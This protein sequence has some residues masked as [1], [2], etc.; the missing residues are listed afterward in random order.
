MDLVSG[1]AEML[2]IWI[3][4][5]SWEEIRAARGFSHV[6]ATIAWVVPSTIIA[7]GIGLT[8]WRETPL[9]WLLGV[10]PHDPDADWAERA[11]DIDK[12]GVQDF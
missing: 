8:E 6:I 1:L 10:S 4:G 3:E 5:G 9:A 12:D 11:R 7:L 2:R